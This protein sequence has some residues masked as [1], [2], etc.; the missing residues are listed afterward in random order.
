[1][2]KIEWT[3]KT[4]NPIVGCSKISSG[5]KNCYAER[6]A[7]RFSGP[8][9]AN[10]GLTV[11]RPGK[12]PEWTGKLRYFRE[13]LEIPK[14]RKKPTMY[15]VNSMSDLFHEDVPVEWID[16]IFEVM[17]ECPQHTFQVLTKRAERLR[18]WATGKILPRNVWMG[19][20]VE[21]GSTTHRINDLVLVDAAVRFLSCE[22]LLSS[23]DLTFDVRS[24]AGKLT[25]AL[26][27]IDWVIVGG[28]SGHGA[29]PMHPACVRQIRDD[30]VRAN[31]PFFFKQ[32]GA[33]A[34]KPRGA[35]P[36]GK[37]AAIRSAHD[38]RET[39]VTMQR[40]GKK[41]A[42]RKLDGRTW[43]QMPGVAG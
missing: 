23:L 21:G 13:R 37:T 9:G 14:K 19:V 31:V 32:W 18:E 12:G 1:M 17:A 35:A 5:C 39:M 40:V 6:F 2:S 41:A 8:G 10:E 7:H 16:E 11:Q 4:W 25:P 30:C 3:E 26:D 38:V 22:P 36:I 27:L 42:G 34:P 29:R 33:W 43:D 15:F 24:L 28:E 20:S